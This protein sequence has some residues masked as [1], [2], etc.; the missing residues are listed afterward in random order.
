MRLFLGIELD[1][2]TRGHIAAHLAELPSMKKGWEHPED[3]HLTMLFI[4][5]VYPEESELIKARLREFQFQPF[6]VKLRALTFFSRRILYLSVDPS[7]E[8][9]RLK[10][11]ID[12]RFGHLAP[13][14]TKVFHPHITLKRWQRHEYETLH[15]AIEAKSFSPMELSVDHLTLFE[16]KKNLGR[17][18]Q[19]LARGPVS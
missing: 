4:G 14:S 16:S 6:T 9:N 11:L 13:P 10:C 7:E 18:Y 3:L 8:L 12:Q 17:K 5:E 1:E 15:Q 19:V 2:T